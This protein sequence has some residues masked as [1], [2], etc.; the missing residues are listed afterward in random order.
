MSLRRFDYYAKTL[1]IVF[2]EQ[3][4]QNHHTFLSLYILMSGTDIGLYG[5]LTKAILLTTGIISMWMV[6]HTRI[7]LKDFGEITASVQ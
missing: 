6:A 7:Q 5:I 1:F 3:E 2:Y 4:E